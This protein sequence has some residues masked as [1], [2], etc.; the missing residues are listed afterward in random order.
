MSPIINLMNL[1]NIEIYFYAVLLVPLCGALLMVIGG[2]WRIAGIINFLI[3][4]ISCIAAFLLIPDFVQRSSEMPLFFWRQ[5]LFLDSFNLLSILLTTFIAATTAFFSHHYMWHNVESGKI[6]R[7]QLRLYHVMYQLFVFMM[8]LTLMANNIGILWVAMEGATLATVLLVS[9]YRSKE[10]VEAAWKY[11]ILCIVGIALALFGTV[12][13]YAAAAP[14]AGQSSAILWNVLHENAAQLNAP[15]MKLAFVFLLVGYGTK[16]G[17]VP[18]HNWLPDAHSE[19]PA[20]MSTLLS[21]LLLNVALYALVRF[22]ILVDMALHSHLA[23]N[24]MVGFGLLSFIVAAILLH[25]QSNIKR[26]FSYSSVEHMGLMTFAFGLGGELATFAALFYMLMHSLAK[27][28]VFM[29]VG[30]VIQL[31]QTQVIDKIRG[32]LRSQPV[33]GWGLLLAVIALSGFPPFGIFTS[34]LMLVIATLKLTPWLAVLVILGLVVA[35]AGLLRN[36]QPV[37]Y[38]DAELLAKS[39]EYSGNAGAGMRIQ[40]QCFGLSMLPALI[41]LTLVFVFGVYIPSVL[42]Q[43]LERA[44]ALIVGN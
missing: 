19:S 33:V 38:G 29:S 43:L 44:T 8:L 9:L 34:E 3:S 21:G 2:G 22:K 41:H 12:L 18:L 31:V 6:S 28:A 36:I 30:N 15:I 20:P 16:I 23:G 10:A 5:Q 4:G 24:L 7:T 26:L 32:I 13:V 35:L 27:S 39:S 42:M 37:V 25:R 14:F 40:H 1:V 17:L 11:F